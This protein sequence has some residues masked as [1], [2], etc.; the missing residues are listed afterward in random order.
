MAKKV[1]E[2]V[3]FTDAS[4]VPPSGLKFVR[5][6]FQFKTHAL[7]FDRCEFHDC[8]LSNN[9]VGVFTNNALWNS[10]LSGCDFRGADVSFT[11]TAPGSPT[12]AVGCRWAGM[13]AI[14]DCG[15]F[16][17]LKVS[18]EDAWILTL[19]GVLVSSPAH[20]AIAAAIPK[21]H[22]PKVRALV[23]RDFRKET[24]RGL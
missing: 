20:D 24:A 19:L 23:R 4:F 1:F 3:E 18:E 15:F 10:D 22:L 13:R 7:A 6:R 2:D 11:I 8:D 14:L 16:A 17:G 12:K 21:K 5:C 9:R